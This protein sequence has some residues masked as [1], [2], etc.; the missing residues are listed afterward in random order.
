MPA[1]AGL[2]L[3]AAVVAVT[4]AFVHRWGSPLGL[5]LALGAAAA[6]AT[7]ARTYARTRLGSGVVA[8]CWLVP[9]LLLA[10]SSPGDDVVIAGDTAGVV[11]LFGGSAVHAVALGM[12]ARENSA[13]TIT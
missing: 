5:A 1:V 6:V 10:Q 3:V 13:R 2:A 11:F 7:L 12:G 4:G 9:V 8:G